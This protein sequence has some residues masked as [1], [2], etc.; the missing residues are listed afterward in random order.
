MG[1]M[2]HR[3][4]ALA[5]F[6]PVFEAPGFVFATWGGGEEVRPGV[7]RMPYC[8]LST[9]ALRFIRVASESELIRPGFDWPQWDQTP[10]AAALL[11]SSQALELAT[12][13]QL[14]R[15]LTVLIRRDRFV[16]GSLAEA[17]RTGYLTAILR[18]AVVL[19][20]EA[21]QGREP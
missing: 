15:V 6:L 21:D 18:R 11:A 2:R 8:S 19:R 16:E 3:L 9:E 13:D 14:A 4:E 1:H 7:R 10:Q 5:A 12:P 20:D 17:F